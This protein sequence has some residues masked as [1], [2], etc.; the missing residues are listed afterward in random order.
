MKKLM[1]MAMIMMAT[2]NA[3]AQ[4]EEG[5]W[6]IMPKVGIS[7]ADLTGK[8]YLATEDASYDA[9]LHP[10]FTYV[11]GIEGEYAVTEQ[12]GLAVGVHYDRQGAKTDH[13]YF[14][15]YMD[16]VNIPLLLQYYPITNVG[17]ALK[18]GAQ[19]GWLS[20]KSVTFDG[21]TYGDN[22]ELSKAFNKVDL[23][24]PLGISFEYAKFVLD[25]RYNWGLTNVLKDD[26]ENSKNSVFQFTLGYKL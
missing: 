13:N 20:H 22:P 5:E 11:V 7:L 24:I 1:M 3:Q 15:V 14:K 25:A 21:T 26:P 8:L 10:L 16:Y 9:T 12:L 19:V 18:A 23:S 6:T 17:L 2:V 4:L